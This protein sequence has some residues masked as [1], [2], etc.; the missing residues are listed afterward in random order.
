MIHR[1]QIIGPEQG[2]C[3]AQVK[4]T[5]GH[6]RVH[7]G[8]VPELLGRERCIRTADDAIELA[9]GVKGAIQQILEEDNERK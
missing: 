7:L 4:F 9:F 5:D 8:T 2:I 1:L 6:G 3:G